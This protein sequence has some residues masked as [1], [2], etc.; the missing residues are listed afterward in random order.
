MYCVCVRVHYT[1][2]TEHSTK[3]DIRLTTG[4]Q[5]NSSSKKEAKL[6]QTLTEQVQQPTSCVLFTANTSGA[7]IKA[8]HGSLPKDM[9]TKMPTVRCA[10]LHGNCLFGCKWFLFH[11]RPPLCQKKKNVKRKEKVRPDSP[12]LASITMAVIS[13]MEPWPSYSSQPENLGNNMGG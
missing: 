3:R 2:S 1:H 5:S 11:R 4:R 12:E 6:D 8:L 10:C 13:N 9:P 7:C